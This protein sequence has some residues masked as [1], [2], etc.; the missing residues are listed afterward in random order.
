MM[1]AKVKLGTDKA[2]LARYLRALYPDVP[3]S[4]D[5]DETGA[6]S[7]QRNGRGYGLYMC[8]NDE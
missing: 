2:P 3:R 1:V 8:G 5:T 6:A 7:D 4:R